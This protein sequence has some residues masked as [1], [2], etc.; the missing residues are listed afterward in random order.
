M[1]YR[2]FLTGTEMDGV[3]NSRGSDQK[4][5]NS[6]TQKS[7]EKKSLEDQERMRKGQGKETLTNAA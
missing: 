3:C 2:K 4:L 1:V 7:E 5:R 6:F